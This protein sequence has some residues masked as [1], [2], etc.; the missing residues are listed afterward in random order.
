M[1]EVV[2]KL[3]AKEDL[4][5]TKVDNCEL[6]NYRLTKHHSACFQILQNTES[7]YFILFIFYLLIFPSLLKIDIKQQ[8]N[9]NNNNKKKREYCGNLRHTRTHTHY[10]HILTTFSFTKPGTYFV[11]QKLWLHYLIFRS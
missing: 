5:Y 10:I 8:Q 4:E 11:P 2:I 6:V 3:E 7:F 1:I 9:D